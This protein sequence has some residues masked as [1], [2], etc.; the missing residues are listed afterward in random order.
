MQSVTSPGP[1]P[2]RQLLRTTSF[3]FRPQRIQKLIICKTSEASKFHL[4]LGGA[5]GDLSAQ[6]ADVRCPPKHLSLPNV[7]LPAKIASSENQENESSK[8][9]SVTQTTCPPVQTRPGPRVRHSPSSQTKPE[10]ILFPKRETGVSHHFPSSTLTKLNETLAASQSMINLDGLRSLFAQTLLEHDR[11][12]IRGLSRDRSDISHLKVRRDT[13]IKKA[14]SIRTSQ[15][16]PPLALREPLIFLE[17]VNDQRLKN[18][19]KLGTELASLALLDIQLGLEERMEGRY[20]FPRV[21]PQR[22]ADLQARMEGLMVKALGFP[23]PDKLPAFFL[24]QTVPKA[25]I[26]HRLRNLGR[27]AIHSFVSLDRY[28]KLGQGRLDFVSE[29]V[30]QLAEGL[31]REPS[32]QADSPASYLQGNLR[33]VKLFHDFSAYSLKLLFEE[34]APVDSGYGNLVLNA[35]FLNFFVTEFSLGLFEEL[36][37]RLG[38][39]GGSKGGGRGREALAELEELQRRDREREDTMLAVRDDLRDLRLENKSLQGQLQE[40]NEAL[41]LANLQV[42]KLK[43]EAS[44]L[45]HRAAVFTGLSRE[46][47]RTHLADPETNVRDPNCQV[48]HKLQSILHYSDMYDEVLQKFAEGTLE[49]EQATARLQDIVAQSKF[50]SVS[51]PEEARHA[52]SFLGTA[53]GLQEASRMSDI[54]NTLKEAEKRKSIFLNN[55]IRR[56]SYMRPEQIIEIMKVEGTLGKVAG[57]TGVPRKSRQSS[58]SK[59]RSES[60]ELVRKLMA[61]QNEEIDNSSG[62]SD[63]DTNSDRQGQLERK[64][65]DDSKETPEA[66]QAKIN[67]KRSTKR[68]SQCLFDA[69]V[70]TDDGAGGESC[71]IADT[72]LPAKALTKKKS[73]TLGGVQFH[74]EPAITLLGSVAG[75]A[76]DSVRS[77]GDV[78]R[79]AGAK[80]GFNPDANRPPHD[81]IARLNRLVDSLDLPQLSETKSLNPGLCF[82]VSEVL[83]AIEQAEEEDVTLALTRKEVKDRIEV[84]GVFLSH[85]KKWHEEAGGDS[86]S[87]VEEA[88]S[89]LEKVRE[90]TEIPGS[91]SGGEFVQGRTL[92][93]QASVDRPP[94]DFVN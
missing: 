80:A 12:R 67:R 74:D 40:A 7:A 28:R 2:P 42:L 85:Q 11:R 77:V 44:L 41:R 81:L 92:K 21:T 63:S 16:G 60:W 87:V 55:T 72:S 13:S 83:G 30:G 19:A 66:I 9:Q 75:G 68:R 8:R 10:G 94:L 38:D 59:R 62:S 15:R 50:D 91:S 79:Q 34:T 51:A 82:Q 76:M 64:D 18:P 37:Q 14:G 1:E 86:S 78:S 17:M 43:E 57:G 52:Q 65:S 48:F 23:A 45:H 36:T 69:A 46:A 27:T 29:Q 90:K 84:L 26:L 56:K 25:D 4:P 32:F 88:L 3:Q 89:R 39:A 35:A 70:Q 54:Q 47:I 24:T 31:V 49:I 53:K 73:R 93:N 58:F 22:F 6:L 33:L 20:F 71:P 5:V 61:Q